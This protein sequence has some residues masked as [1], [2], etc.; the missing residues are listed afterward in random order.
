MAPTGTLRLFAGTAESVYHDWVVEWDQDGKLLK[1][2]QYDL[3]LLIN[4]ER[5]SEAS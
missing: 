1:A 4:T 2:E 3:G 5:R